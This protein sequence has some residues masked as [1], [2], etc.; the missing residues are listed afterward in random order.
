[1]NYKLIISIMVMALLTSSCTRTDPFPDCPTDEPEVWLAC[2]NPRYKEAESRGMNGLIEWIK[3][4]M[5][6]YCT[7]EIEEWLPILDRSLPNIVPKLRDTIV[8]SHYPPYHPTLSYSGVES[9]S[10]QDLYRSAMASI[11]IPTSQKGAW[12]E[13]GSCRELIEDYDYKGFIDYLDDVDAQRRASEED[14]RV[15]EE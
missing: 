2:A 4:S 6:A 5:T 14:L 3:Q 10:N 1:M 7:E 8:N 9:L 11:L 12:G 15:R 13:T